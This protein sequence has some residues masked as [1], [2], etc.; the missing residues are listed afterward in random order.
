MRE[1][2]Q[3]NKSTV[4]EQGLLLSRGELSSAERN[5][6][7]LLN[8]F[9]V[10]WSVQ[11]FDEFLG[12]DRTS[13][14]TR[15]FCSSETY[16]ELVKQL[17]NSSELTRRWQENVHSAFI[18]SAEDET[19]LQELANLLGGGQVAHAVG[20]G[21]NAAAHFLVSDDA[22]LCGVMAGV[23]V[24]ASSSPTALLSGPFGRGIRSII[25]LNEQ[26]AFVL[27]RHRDIALFLSASSQIVDLDAELAGGIF[28]IREHALT[29][30][31]IALYV[32]WAF[33]LSCWQPA[34]VTACLI[35][36]DPLLK[37]SHGFVDF[38]EL[39]SLMK[40]H[41]FS[42]NIAFIPWNWRRSNPDVVRLFLDNSESYSISVHGCD[43]TRAEFGSENVQQSSARIRR[44]LAR[45]AEHERRSGIHHDRV[46]VFPQ[47][48]FSAAAMAALKQSEL[49][50]A[51][52]NDT[53]SA[54]EPPLPITISDV[55][56][57][58]V[59]KYGGFPLF[60]RRYPW[61][62]IENFAFDALLGKPVLLVIHHESCRDH[63]RRL[64]DFID[65]LNASKVAPVW[66]NLT[67][68]VR[69]SYRQRRPSEGAVEVEMF[70]T[71]LLLENCSG[72]EEDFT[73]RREESTPSSIHEIHVDSRS[74]DWKATEHGVTFGTRLKAGESAL[75]KLTFKKQEAERQERNGRSEARIMLRRYLC[76]VRDNYVTRGKVLFTAALGKKDDEWV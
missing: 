27:A 22:E 40:R 7:K 43:H 14:A 57:V 49:I 47:G 61:E 28:D 32:K 20:N 66:R 72:E 9:G 15:V 75:I 6:G 58:A 65:R 67:E 5:I 8:F 41:H 64:I 73:V 69:R 31:P 52:N 3:K 34:E 70:A 4:T 36:D 37:R 23:R 2:K 44:A 21:G 51:V 19:S 50:A 68:V 12:G 13:Q 1:L 16:L 74:I 60:T 38:T 39:L 24:K 48:V 62:G 30:I 10:P 18:Y 29:A 11:P 42:A 71:E 63:C 46:M 54:D 56:N 35:I 45:M 25:S 17:E 55:W 76:E 59:M 33:A 53:I 26:S